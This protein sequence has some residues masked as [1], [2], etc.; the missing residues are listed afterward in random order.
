MHTKEYEDGYR[1]AIADYTAGKAYKPN[2]LRNLGVL[3]L[4]PQ[5]RDEF[6]RGYR[7]GYQECLDISLQKEAREQLG[8]KAFDT[9]LQSRSPDRL[10][11]LKQSRKR[12]PEQ[13]GQEPD[14]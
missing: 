6:L 11:E 3:T 14:Y 5:K 2:K 8:I 12:H 9:R 4:N 10:H 13:P 7:F 1:Q